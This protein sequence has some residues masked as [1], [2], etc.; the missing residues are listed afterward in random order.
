M[1][2]KTVKGVIVTP[3]TMIV[4]DITIRAEGTRKGEKNFITVSLSD[5]KRGVMLQVNYEDIKE[6][7]RGV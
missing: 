6:L 2:A 7:V 5:D 1:N 4:D 3:Y